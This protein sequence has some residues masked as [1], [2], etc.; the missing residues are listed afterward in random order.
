MCYLRSSTS[1]AQD[2]LVRAATGQPYNNELTKFLRSYD[3]F[4]ES[5]LNAQLTVVHSAVVRH[6]LSIEENLTVDTIVDIL[7]NTT[8]AQTLLDQ[9]CRMT[10]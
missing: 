7:K 9:V 2:L 8:G 5:A 3:D 6:D 10:K 1:N 4:D